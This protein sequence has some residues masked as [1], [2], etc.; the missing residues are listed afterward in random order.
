M[1]V[2]GTVTAG[3]SFVFTCTVAL[4]EADSEQPTVVW[5]APVDISTAPGIMQGTTTQDP[6]N[7][8]SRTLEFTT[9]LTS[10]AGDYTCE[11][12]TSA[13]VDMETATLTVGSECTESFTLTCPHKMDDHQICIYLT[14]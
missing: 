10:H 8:F 12:S 4:S 14:V 6:G 11:G 3:E 9:V 1:P 5:T 2:S 13:G 7:S